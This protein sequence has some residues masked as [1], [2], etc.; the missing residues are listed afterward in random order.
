M[1]Y[2]AEKT[3]TAKVCNAFTRHFEQ[4]DV[5][6]IVCMYREHLYANTDTDI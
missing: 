6:M 1:V 3:V 4:L 5:C 2:K